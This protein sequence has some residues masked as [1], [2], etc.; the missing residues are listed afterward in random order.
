VA[1]LLE[2]PRAADLPALE[3]QLEPIQRRLARH[4]P[5][6]RRQVDRAQRQERVQAKGADEPARGVA[7]ARDDAADGVPATMS[8]TIAASVS[9]MARAETSRSGRPSAE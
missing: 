5:H 3:G 6:D 2:E 7:A 1:Q 4:R 8:A 9:P